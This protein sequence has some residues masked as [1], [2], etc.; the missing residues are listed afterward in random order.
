MRWDYVLGYTC[1]NDVSD[2]DNQKLDG[3]FVRAKGYD[4]YAPIGPWIETELDPTNLR[5]QCTVNDETRQDSS[6]AN[7]I[8]PVAELIAFISGVMTL[9]PGDVIMTGTPEGVGPLVGGDTCRITLEHIGVLENPVR[10]LGGELTEM[11]LG[12]RTGGGGD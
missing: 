12:P 4:T 11:V 1:G 5:I 9:E 6:T 7:M 10:R 8:W 2:R 3:Q